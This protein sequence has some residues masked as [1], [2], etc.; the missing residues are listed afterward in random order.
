M[1]DSAVVRADTSVRVHGAGGEHVPEILLAPCTP[2][3][4]SR[5]QAVLRASALTSGLASPHSKPIPPKV[6]D[7]C[8]PNETREVRDE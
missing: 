5:E 4:D 6:R 2:R 8:G 1:T 3:A 7:G